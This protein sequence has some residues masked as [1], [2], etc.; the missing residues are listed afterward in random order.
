M[1]TDI[2]KLKES[3]VRLYVK[4]KFFTL[5]L[6]RHWNKFPR[7]V[8]DVLFLEIFK[9]KLE[10]GFEQPDLVEIVPDY[11]QGTGLFLMSLPT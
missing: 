6:V 10:Q 3:I 11:G 9:T 5:R 1:M 2:F 4:K 8:V 7:V